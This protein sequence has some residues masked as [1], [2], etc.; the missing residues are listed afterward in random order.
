MTSKKWQW[1]ENKNTGVINFN[2]PMAGLTHQKELPIGKH[3]IQLYSLATP[4]G[5]KITIMLEELLALGYSDA[6]Y[7][8]HL[9]RISN[10]EQFGS[11]FVGINP[12]SKIPAML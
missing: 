9:I 6:E 3:P 8:A 11:D 12:N 4:N 2:R 5:V 7:D 1:D 10:G